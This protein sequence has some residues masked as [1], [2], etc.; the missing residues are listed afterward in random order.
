MN[1]LMVMSQ[2]RLNQEY[3]MLNRI[4][5]GFVNDGHQVVRVVPSTPNDELTPFEKAVS[6]AKRITTPVPVFFL[7]RR[8]RSDEILLQLEKIEVDVIIAF[9]A[10]ALEVAS[11]ISSELG[12]PILKEVLSMQEAKKV[13]K[14]SNISRWFAPTPSIE[15][16]IANRAGEERVVFVP[17]A[18][19]NTVLPEPEISSQTNFCISVLDGA[20][21]PKATK[22]ILEAVKPIQDSHLFIELTGR[23]RHKVWK[24]VEQLGM[25]DRVTTLSDMATLRS[26]VTQSDL[27]LLPSETM[28]IRTILLEV[29]LATIPVI[30]T[31]IDG[32][33]MLIDDETALLVEDE[34]EAS[35]QRIINDS[36]L[37]TRLGQSASLL[38]NEQYS[39]SAQIAA[40]EHSF[41][42]I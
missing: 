21:N 34:W 41:T 25:L 15:R 7:L 31:P 39:S 26:L 9:G 1:I 37:A 23:H 42:L 5:V 2:D 38:I 24:T 29:M 11:D 17:I 10:D 12:A 8:T 22:S 28:P 40:F 36:K 18:A 33:D 19:S 14:S 13:R 20:A 16:V 30:A 32:F 27:V 35:I 3:A 6:L 4:V